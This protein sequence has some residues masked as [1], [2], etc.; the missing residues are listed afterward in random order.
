MTTTKHPAHTAIT[1]LKNQ[2][3]LISQAVAEQN[4]ILYPDADNTTALHKIQ[5]AELAYP[6]D[7]GQA[8]QLHSPVIALLQHYERRAD[9]K[10]HAGYFAAL[11][12]EFRD[13]ADMYEYAKDKNHHDKTQY[14]NK[15][16]ELIYTIIRNLEDICTDFAENVYQRLENIADLELRIKENQRAL[17]QLDK[18]THIFNGITPAYLDTIAQQNHTTQTLINRRLAPAIGRNLNQLSDAA[19]RLRRCLL[20]WQKDLKN[21]QRN[22]LLDALSK[23][24]QNHP[25][26]TPDYALYG[27]YPCH[28]RQPKRPTA[29]YADTTHPNADQYY[30]A[31]ATQA[32]QYLAQP[33]DDSTPP[34]STTITDTTH[35]TPIYTRLSPLQSAIN[36]LYRS[37][38][39]P[40]GPTKITAIE[41]YHQLNPQ[42]KLSHW[43]RSADMYYRNN[44]DNFHPTISITYHETQDPRYNGNQTIHDFTLTR[45][46]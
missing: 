27:D 1:T 21:Q 35:S 37:L 7:D 17:T 41:A 16:N 3:P 38:Q 45:Q 4:G 32:A 10:N 33:L 6:I 18:I 42:T 2:F 8:L 24:Y 20:R 34:Q 12:D 22:Q 36:H 26:Y 29:H 15:L 44:R 46:T 40:K 31:L 9:F 13:S 14:E 43:L 25:Q 5:R 30:N 28:R 23:H 11:M 39:D 19:D